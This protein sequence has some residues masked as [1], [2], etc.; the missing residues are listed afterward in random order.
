MHEE[1][2]VKEM[3]RE[4]IGRL[5]KLAHDRTVMADADQLSRRY[6]KLAKEMSSHYKVKMDGR[7]KAS[8]CKKCNA[9]LIPGK[10]CTVTIASSKGSI[11][12]R[13]RC[14]AERKLYYNQ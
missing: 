5:L 12:Y 1:K 4:R 6:V 3:A 14:G 8:F 9:M 13:C 10:T 11:I 7:E 2:I